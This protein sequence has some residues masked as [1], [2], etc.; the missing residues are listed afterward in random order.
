MKPVAN[1]DKNLAWIQIVCSTKSEA[2]VQQYAAVCDVDTL[3]IY[4]NPLAKVFADGEVERGMRLE[5]V[6]RNRWVPVREPRGVVN[7]SRCI[8]SPGQRELSADVQRVS[9]I[10]VE[11]LEAIAEGEIGETAGD[12]AEPKGELIGV[13]QVQLSSIANARRAQREFPP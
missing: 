4:G 6:A 13:G 3:N 7:V 9:L 11:K 8:A 1:L 12:V 5:M 2:V 10:V